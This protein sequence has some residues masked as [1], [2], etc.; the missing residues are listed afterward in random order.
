MMIADQ[1][2]LSFHKWNESQGR[3]PGLQIYSQARIGSSEPGQRDG[4]AARELPKRLNGA[5]AQLACL[6]AVPS[7]L[8]LFPAWE[9]AHQLTFGRLATCEVCW[10]L[11]RCSDA[12]IAPHS[13]S[14]A[15][16]ASVCNLHCDRL[17]NLTCVESSARGL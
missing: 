14:L 11:L 3:L 5:F 15:G 8:P 7:Q 17:M 2:Y 6:P 9:R 1:L 12:R 4:N 16:R 13:R 10:A